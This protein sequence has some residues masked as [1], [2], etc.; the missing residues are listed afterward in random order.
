[1]IMSF[2]SKIS[3]NDCFSRPINKKFH[4]AAVF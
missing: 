3:N 2:S 4:L 1:M